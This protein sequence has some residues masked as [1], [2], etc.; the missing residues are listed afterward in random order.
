MLPHSV[1]LSRRICRFLWSK[2]DEGNEPWKMK[3]YFKEIEHHAFLGTEHGLQG[4]SNSKPPQWWKHLNRICVLCIF[5]R[6]IQEPR[7]YLWYIIQFQGLKFGTVCS[8]FKKTVKNKKN[9]FYVTTLPSKYRNQFLALIKMIISQRRPFQTQ[10][11]YTGLGV[12]K[13]KDIFSV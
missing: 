3:N 8:S 13:S 10:P 7:T 6:G 2:T 11:L 12:P 5:R 1:I 9:S 4:R